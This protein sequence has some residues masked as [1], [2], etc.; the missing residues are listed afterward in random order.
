VIAGAYL[1][2][3]AQPVDREAPPPRCRRRRRLVSV[4]GRGR[5]VVTTE[6]PP[7]SRCT[8]SECQP[9]IEEDLG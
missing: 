1:H 5:L 6:S 2:T 7:V 3:M 8:C 9:A 4:L